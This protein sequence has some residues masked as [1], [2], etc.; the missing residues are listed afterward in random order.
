MVDSDSAN[1]DGA[2]GTGIGSMLGGGRKHEIETLHNQ[3]K[4]IKEALD[5]YKGKTLEFLDEGLE[6]EIVEI[7]GAEMTETVTKKA[8]AE[9]A[10]KLSTNCG[11]QIEWEADITMDDMMRFAS[12]NIDLSRK[13]KIPFV[14]VIVTAKE[15]RLDGYRNPSLTF[16]PRIINLKER[17]ADAALERIEEKLAKGEPINELLLI[18]LPLYGS[19]SGRTVAELLKRALRLTPKVAKDGFE[20]NKLQSLLVLL[21][22]SI[23]KKEDMTKILEESQMKIEGNSVLE[24]LTERGRTQGIEQIAQNMLLREDDPSR[25]SEITGLSLERLREIEAGLDVGHAGPAAV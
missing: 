11:M 2:M 3:D 18:Y 24:I 23:V 9:N 1:E 13:H 19:R 15:H 21:C 17:D 8:H 22:G 12:Y 20:L 4:V 16:T 25:I 5:I 7:L 14:T 10:Y 6:G